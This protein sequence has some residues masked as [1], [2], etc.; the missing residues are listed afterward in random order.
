MEINKIYN[1]SYQEGLSKIDDK[2][3]DLVITDPPY[4][5]NKECCRKDYANSKSAF[6]KSE[7]YLNEGVMMKDLNDFG[8]AEIYEFLNSLPRVMKKMNAYICCAEAQIMYYQKW[9]AD[10]KYRF[11]ILAWEKPL[12]IISKNRFSQNIE[13]IVRIYQLGCGLNKVDENQLYNRVDHSSIVRGKN[14]IHPTQ[15]PISLMEKFIKVSSNEGDIIL[16]P[17]MGSA[18]TA[19]AALMNNRNFI[20]FEKE[21]KYF[22]DGEKRINEFMNEKN[23]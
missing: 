20:G 22:I 19:I 13:F 12:S 10:N 23:S 21:E 9:A 3:I 1:M 16:D 7:L 4:L 14:K 8:E 5:F 6:A 15:K 2:S 17:F 11:A 18:T